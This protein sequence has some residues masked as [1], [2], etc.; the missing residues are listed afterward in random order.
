MASWQGRKVWAAGDKL[1]AADLDALVDQSVMVFA[2]TTARDT[3]IPSPTTGM[4]CFVT[5]DKWTY[6][7]NGTVWV[8][9]NNATGWTA[10]TPSLSGVTI[11]NGAYGGYYS[12]AGKT[13]NVRLVIFGGTTTTFAS[14]PIFGLPFASTYPYYPLN[15]GLYLSGNYVVSCLQLTPSTVAAYIANSATASAYL[16]TPVGVASLTS[17]S[18]IVNLTYEA[19]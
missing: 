1:G 11:G 2:T 9:I 6:Q 19:A 8:A 17:N 18:L 10:Y 5:A 3:A 12:L 7:Y 14:V 4:T 15:S 13:V 16:S